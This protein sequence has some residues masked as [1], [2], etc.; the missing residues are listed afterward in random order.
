LGLKLHNLHAHNKKATYHS[1]EFPIAIA[2]ACQILLALCSA[3]H[4]FDTGLSMNA[5]KTD[6]LEGEFGLKE[7]ESLNEMD[8][9]M[10]T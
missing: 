9:S 5:M 6:R 8:R 7:K 4:C 3:D 1:I 10:N 2:T